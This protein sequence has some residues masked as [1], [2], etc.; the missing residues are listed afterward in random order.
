M[1]KIFTILVIS[2]IILASG[3][4][5]Y[6]FW[7]QNQSTEEVVNIDPVELLVFEVKFDDLTDY[8]K[9]IAFKRFNNAKNV[10]MANI[11]DNNETTDSNQNFQPWLEVAVAQKSIG[12]FDRA[13]GIWIWFTEAYDKNSISPANLGDL[14]KSFVVDNEL[15]EKYYKIAIERDTTDWFTYYS[16]YELY[17][18]NFNDS[19]K[20]I[21]VLRDGAS[22][23]PDNKNYVA[24]LAN[25]YIIIGDKN[26]AKE[27][28]EEFVA[29]HP[30]EVSL[31]DKLK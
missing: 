23:N 31:R 21:A 30:E 29:R 10:I 1:K 13:A 26:S 14:Y 6:Y 12:D 25:Y 5:G 8:Q 28:I 27:V 2:V 16:F 17:R 15:S 7:Q 4:A 9:D 20:A 3:L 24:E 22:H 11:N 18:Y 19:E